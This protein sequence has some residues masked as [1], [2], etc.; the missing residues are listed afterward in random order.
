VRF[1]NVVFALIFFSGVKDDDT[2][3]GLVHPVAVLFDEV[4]LLLQRNRLFEI[5]PIDDC[6]VAVTVREEC[7]LVEFLG[8]VDCPFVNEILEV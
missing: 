4:G 7:V 3:V 2:G 1:D 5:V 6:R 8:D